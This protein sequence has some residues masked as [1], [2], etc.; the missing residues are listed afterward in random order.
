[1]LLLIDKHSQ[2]KFMYGL[3]N[4]TTSLHSAICQFIWDC[5]VKPKL[6]HTDFD[7]K[8]MGGEVARLLKNEKVCIE[9]SP[10]YHQHQNGLVE[11]H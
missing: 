1:M 8:L 11:H 3:K 7:Q 6:I 4:L 5:G 9:S 10:P 2:Y